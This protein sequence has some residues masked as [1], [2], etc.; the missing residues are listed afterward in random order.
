[1]NLG[2]GLVIW[3]GTLFR[4]NVWDSSN[5]ISTLVEWSTLVLID[6]SFQTLITRLMDWWFRRKKRGTLIRLCQR[7]CD[8]KSCCWPEKYMETQANCANCIGVFYLFSER[9]VLSNF[10]VILGRWTCSL[11]PKIGHVSL[12]IQSH[13]QEYF[14]FLY[15]VTYRNIYGVP[16]RLKHEPYIFYS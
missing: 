7:S 16:I 4:S 3:W 9:W 10:H 2:Y 11:C 1:M 13:V 14:D 15:G 6:W 8:K 5:K 12:F